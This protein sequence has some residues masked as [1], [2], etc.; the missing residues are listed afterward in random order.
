MKMGRALY[1]D[2]N[3]VTIENVDDSNASRL[4]EPLL[5]DDAEDKPESD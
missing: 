4:F 5:P 3:K 2:S 1:K